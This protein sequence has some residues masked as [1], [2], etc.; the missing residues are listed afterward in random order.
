MLNGADLLAVV[1]GVMALIVAMGVFFSF[2]AVRRRLIVLQGRGRSEDIL[3][4]VSRQAEAVRALR[5]DIQ[6]LSR[7]LHALHEA[8][9]GTLQ[10]FAVYRYD[11]FEDMGG[12]LSFSAAILNDFGDGLVISCING[13]TEART[14]AKPVA[15]ATSAF[16][17]SP[18]E[19]EAIRLALS[20][21]AR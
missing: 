15:R 1:L 10:R 3:E 16:N 2:A 4:A 6:H 18:E 9:R 21:A 17:L 14:Y 20:G 19:Q 5:E 13:R 12:Q 8:F 7:E 11:A